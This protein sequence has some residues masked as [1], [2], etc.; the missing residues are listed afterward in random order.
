MARLKQTGRAAVETEQNSPKQ[1]TFSH[2]RA[3]RQSGSSLWHHKSQSHPG[4]T[5]CQGN[6]T[7]KS[8][9]YFY[10]RTLLAGLGEVKGIRESV[11][12]NWGGSECQGQRKGRG[13]ESRR[14]KASS[15][16]ANKFKTLIYASCQDGPSLSQVKRCWD[17]APGYVC[18]N[19][20]GLSSHS[21]AVDSSVRRLLPSFTSVPICA[22]L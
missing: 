4:G 20:P 7:K 15:A 8:Y 18:T 11:W 22:T 13:R 3:Q 19:H 21:S 16:R 2:L 1:L 5:P 14:A 17:G 9:K 10:I 6:K 12:K